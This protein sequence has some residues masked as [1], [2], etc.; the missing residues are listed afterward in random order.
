MYLAFCTV[1]FPRRRRKNNNTFVVF[2]I[3]FCLLNNKWFQFFFFWN[4]RL[5]SKLCFAH[6]PLHRWKQQP[7]IIF[8]WENCCLVS[9]YTW[10]IN[11]P[12]DLNFLEC[13]ADGLVF[14]KKFSHAN[15]AQHVQCVRS[16][17]VVT[18]HLS[19]SYFS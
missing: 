12:G 4:L 5:E 19:Y 3:H 16:T 18:S 1:P 10:K 7:I 13:T 9:H 11:S 15:E 8:P 2:F 6:S 17:L 14:S